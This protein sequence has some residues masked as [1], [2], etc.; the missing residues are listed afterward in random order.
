MKLAVEQVVVAGTLGYGAAGAFDPHRRLACALEAG[1]HRDAV[2]A[3]VEAYAS[4]T[5][6]ESNRA[7]IGGR[8]GSREA[9]AR[10]GGA[11]PAPGSPP[12]D[13]D[14][15]LEEARD[16]VTL[17]LDERDHLRPDADGGRREGRLVL[18]APVDPEQLRV[19][20]A[21]PEHVTPLVDARP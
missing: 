2:R 15:A 9:P 8:R 20:A 18:G 5:R 10:P 19:L 14:P 12:A 13:D 21:D 7:G 16:E 3:A 4:T 6:K 1:R 11:A 17:G